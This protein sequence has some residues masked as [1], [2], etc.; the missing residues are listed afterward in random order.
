[1]IELL[2][3]CIVVTKEEH[4]IRAFKYLATELLMLDTDE[5]GCDKIRK[6]IDKVMIGNLKGRDVETARAYLKKSKYGLYWYDGI[7]RG[8]RDVL[9]R[10]A[11]ALIEVYNVGGSASHGCLMGYKFFDESYGAESIEP[12]EDPYSANLSTYFSILL[13]LEF[14]GVRNRFEKL[15]LDKY[16]KKYLEEFVTLRPDIEATRHKTLGKTRKGFCKRWL[17]FF[18]IRCRR[19]L[20]WI[21][22]KRR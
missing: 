2:V 10:E 1:M 5:D 19:K 17:D 18:T 3:N 7:Y 21:R 15:G 9:K 20:R 6:E 11:P 12:R 13:L 16:H 8:P 4:E 14:C 22:L